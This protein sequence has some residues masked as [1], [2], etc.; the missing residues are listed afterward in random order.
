MSKLLHISW[1]DPKKSTDL[2]PDV[3]KGI[4]VEK[5]L[6]KPTGEYFFLGTIDEAEKLKDRLEKSIPKN[7]YTVVREDNKPTG[8]LRFEPEITILNL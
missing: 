7:R 4:Q 3:L 2:Y 6:V 5:R 8:E 1:M